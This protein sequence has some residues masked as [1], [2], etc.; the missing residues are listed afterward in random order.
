MPRR[1]GGEDTIYRCEN[2]RREGRI[3]LGYV[4][5][6][7]VRKSVLGRTR[8]EDQERLW[9]LLA[10]VSRGLFIRGLWVRVPPGLPRKTSAERGTE[11]VVVAA[12]GQETD[13]SSS[14]RLRCAAGRSTPQRRH[15]VFGD[16]CCR[17]E[18]NAPPAGKL[19]NG[20][21]PR[22]W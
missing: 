4:N 14:L 9:K 8:R 5:G 21:D 11:K 2:G 19:T 16:R 15:N 1:G 7:Q 18:R 3:D 13:H 17:A 20:M 10:D 22:R 12:A 6:H